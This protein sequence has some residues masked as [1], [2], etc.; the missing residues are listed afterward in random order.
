MGEIVPSEVIE[1]RIFLIRGQKVMIDRDLAELYGVKSK[2]LNQ[3][4]KRNIE[5]F[6]GEFMLQLTKKEKDELV[7]FCHRFDSMKHSTSL[8]YAFTEHGVAMLAS[9]LSSEKAI[10]IS[11]VII[12]TFVKLREIISTHKELA[13]KLSELENKIEKHD[14]EIQS[15]F[16]AIRQLMAP[17]PEP[18]KRR[19]GF[20]QD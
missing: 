7:S 8:P 4:V 3:Q 11:I 17:P 13:H 18:P 1:K 5:R 15:I 20:M 14:V 10:K 9:M 2:H 19:I 16:E 12:K 6:P